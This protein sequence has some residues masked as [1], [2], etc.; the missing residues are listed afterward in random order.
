MDHKM[1]NT[2]KNET[3]NSS[4]APQETRRE[5]KTETKKDC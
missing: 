2:K 5:N 4:Y 1:N 3:K